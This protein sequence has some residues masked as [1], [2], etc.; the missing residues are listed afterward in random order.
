MKRVTLGLAALAAMLL[1]GG[2]VRGQEQAATFDDECTKVLQYFIGSWE[3]AGEGEGG[4]WKYEGTREW[5]LDKKF[6]LCKIVFTLGDE[7]IQFRM[8]SGWDVPSKTLRDWS[9]GA[10]GGHGTVV[11]KIESRGKLFT[12]TGKSSGVN[13]E[14]KKTSATLRIEVQDENS[15]VWEAKDRKEGDQ[16]L[17]DLRVTARRKRS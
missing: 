15:Y 5:M 17:P 13:G 10:R 11:W 14:G 9:F 7:Q 3:A 12:L 8:V 16:S 4:S 1:A 2:S 6:T